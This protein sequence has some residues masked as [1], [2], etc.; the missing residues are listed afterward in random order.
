MSFL[1]LSDATEICDALDLR[2]IEQAAAMGIHIHSSEPAEEVVHS[3]LQCSSAEVEEQDSCSKQP[4][5]AHMAQH[6]QVADIDIPHMEEVHNQVVELLLA[7]LPMEKLD[8]RGGLALT[9]N[10]LEVCVVGGGDEDA[11]GM[12]AWDEGLETFRYALVDQPSAQIFRIIIKPDKTQEG[13]ELMER[14]R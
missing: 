6:I 8:A 10:N 3:P 7:G 4:T 11:P 14:N 2:E 13:I 9:D 1:C 5:E 12:R